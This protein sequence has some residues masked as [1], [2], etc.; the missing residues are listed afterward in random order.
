MIM[1]MNL[2][3]KKC[4]ECKR[5]L[6]F[7]LFG[8]KSNTKDGLRYDCRECREKDWK[9]KKSIYKEK[10]KLF[11]QLNKKRLS[12]KSHLYHQKIKKKNSLFSSQEIREKTSQKMCNICKK[13]LPS[14]KFEI[15]RAFIDGLHRACRACRSLQRKIKTHKVTEEWIL[16]K[17]KTN[18]QK[19]PI[20]EKTFP[21]EKLFI[22]HNHSTGKSRDLICTRCN[23][24]LGFARENR[25]ILLNAITYLDK[26]NKLE[27][28]CL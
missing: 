25:Q 6:P 22:D 8:K 21:S 20:C 17:L 14:E 4:S 16:N 3:T 12:K 7:I 1:H 19:C 11:Y 27:E 9:I 5:D 23:T 2:K 10:Q 15:N 26:Y 13:M 18:N 24:L 28:K